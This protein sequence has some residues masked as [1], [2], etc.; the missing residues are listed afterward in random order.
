MTFLELGDDVE[1][2][3]SEDERRLVPRLAVPLYD[4]GHPGTVD[5]HEPAN[6]TEHGEQRI[7]GRGQQLYRIAGNV[8]SNDASIAVQNRAA[9]RSKRNGPE[10]LGLCLELKL[11]VLDDL[12]TEESAAE[13][14]EGRNQ[15]HAGNVCTLP[16]P[17]GIEAVHASSRIENMLRNVISTTR[18]KP[19]VVSACSGLYS[20]SSVISCR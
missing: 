16:K 14:H 10:P 7:G 20:V 12:G 19:A 13:H 4:V 3:V 5:W 6:P 17:I 2:S 9:R 11:V 18:A 1:G 15:N 8:F